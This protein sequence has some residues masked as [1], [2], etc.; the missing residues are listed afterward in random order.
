MI[1]NYKHTKKK[2]KRTTILKKGTNKEKK[3]DRKGKKQSI[4][5]PQQNDKRSLACTQHPKKKG[6]KKTQKLFSLSPT[7]PSWKGKKMGLWGAC[8]PTSLVENYFYS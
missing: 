1:F 7:I 3:S 6:K 4:K 2:E 8:W 5:T